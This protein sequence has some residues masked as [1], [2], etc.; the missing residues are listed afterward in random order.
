MRFL[1]RIKRTTRQYIMVAFICIT[2]I[3]IAAIATSVTVIGQIR[4][5]YEYMLDEADREMNENKKSVWV[6]LSDIKSGEVLSEEKVEERIVYSSQPAESYISRG[7]FGKAVLIDIPEGT[8]IIKSMVAKNNVPAILREVEYDVI[9]VSSNIEVNNFI[10]V[11]IFYPNGETFVVLSKKQL[12]GYQPDTAVC[13]LWV[14]EEELLR[15][16]AAIVDAALYTGSKLY[17]TK[18]IEPNVQEPSLITYTPGISVLKLIENDP[19]IVDRCSQ[20]LNIEVR[21]ALENRL[22]ASMETEVGN[23]RWD[24][25]EDTVR[26]MP[27]TG[28]FTTAAGQTDDIGT[29][30]ESDEEYY[31]NNEEND[32]EYQQENHIEND[33]SYHKRNNEKYNEENGKKNVNDAERPDRPGSSESSDIES[34]NIKDKKSATE[35]SNTE[36]SST[37][38]SDTVSSDKYHN[39]ELGQMYDINYL[40]PSEG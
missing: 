32:E 3:G 29:K 13:Y 31:E 37:E 17:M 8:H 2:V 5:E 1:R 16:S 39:P 20:I 9:Q 27:E 36:K 7:D 26:Y 21:K 40:L 28:T 12:K 18:Y 11:R 33:K 4:Q 19:N 15:M 34:T 14:D 22:S 24:I 25:D 10:D 6:A 35:R 38:K 23:I 30:E